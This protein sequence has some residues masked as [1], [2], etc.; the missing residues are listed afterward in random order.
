MRELDAWLKIVP[1]MPKWDVSWDK[2]AESPV[3]QLIVDMKR[4]SQ[5]PKFHAE[6]DVWTH[7][8]MVCEALISLDEFRQLPESR[9]AILFLAALFHDAGKPACTRWEDDRWTSPN[10]GSVGAG[11][12]RRFLW[13]ECGLCGTPEK[14][15]FRETICHLIRYHAV[16]AHIIS[17]PDAHRRLRKIA[18]NQALLPE[19]SLELL[20]LLSKADA[21]GRI[22]E[23]MDDMLYRTGLARELAVE[24]ECYRD[25][26]G[27]YSD[28]SRYAYL[29]GRNILPEQPIYDDNWGEVLMVSGLPGTGKDTW[30]RENHP[31]LPVIS[32]DDI[33]MEL[34][35]PPTAN[36]TPVVETAR[37]R[38]KL[39]LR[40]KQPFVWNATNLS[41]AIRQRQVGLFRDYGAGV[42]IVYLETA[43][44]EMLRRNSD[45]K[46][47]VPEQAICG[48]MQHLTP[49]EI[50]EACSVEWI[51]V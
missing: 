15:R 49:P 47:V 4:T 13:Q 10:H 16:P 1:T 37:E 20:C 32:L 25:C 51:C 18:A 9:R 29:N 33:R 42:R 24:G 40:K 23:D 43:W 26:C 39:L 7:T 36:Q 5:N 38:A 3:K 14:Q 22:S 34:K 11:I 46:A 30:I 31:D 17:D 35:I 19:F 50:W 2:I 6:G 45:R 27:F 21:L 48:M 8:K 12:V 28:Y 41:S 44:D